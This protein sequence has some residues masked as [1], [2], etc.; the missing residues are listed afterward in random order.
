MMSE[1]WLER[2]N[3]AITGGIQAPDEVMAQA[4]MAIG[5][6]LANIERLLGELVSTAIN[7]E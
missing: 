1:Y 2:A 4:L 5:V 7:H 3:D 6:S